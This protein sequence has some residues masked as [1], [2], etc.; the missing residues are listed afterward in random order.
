[1]PLVRSSICEVGRCPVDGGPCRRASGKTKRWVLSVRRPVEVV[2][3][4]TGKVVGYYRSIR[5]TVEATNLTS[6]KY[7]IEHHIVADGVYYRFAGMG[8]GNGQ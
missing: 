4:I 6:V 2:D 7:R 3:A 5:A 1:V 8:D